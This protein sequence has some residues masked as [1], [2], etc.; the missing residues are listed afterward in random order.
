MNPNPSIAEQLVAHVAARLRDLPEAP[1]DEHVRRD[2]LTPAEKE[3]C[4]L[5]DIQMGDDIPEGKATANLCEQNRKLSIDIAVQVRSDEAN[6]TADPI[7]SAIYAAMNPTTPYPFKA[8]ITDRGIRRPKPEI[9][10]QDALEVV[11]G[12]DLSYTCAPW[13]LT[14][15]NAD[16]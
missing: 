2:H 16:S 12:F 9:A 14:K 11:L 6:T 4:P 8:R 3:E 10:D 7:V 5:I 1:S 15:Q 13:E